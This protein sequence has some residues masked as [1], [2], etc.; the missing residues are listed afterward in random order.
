MQWYVFLTDTPITKG[1]YNDQK[2]I[3]RSHEHSCKTEQQF[4]MKAAIM[5]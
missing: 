1:E 4:L 3:V 5:T 2:I